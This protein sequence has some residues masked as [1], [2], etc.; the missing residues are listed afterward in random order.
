MEPVQFHTPK[1]ETHMEPDDMD[2]TGKTIEPYYIDP[3][4]FCQ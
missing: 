4:C 3:L 2:L 1:N